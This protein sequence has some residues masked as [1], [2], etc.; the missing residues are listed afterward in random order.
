M[1]ASGQ[2]S[3]PLSLLGNLS[4]PPTT[5][6]NQ[7]S[8]PFSNLGN[9]TA[10]PTAASGQSSDPFGNLGSVTAPGIAGSS[11]SNDPFAYLANISTTPV[12]S[13]P[14]ATTTTNNNALFAVSNPTPLM[15]TE[16]AM[17]TA[18]PTY[19][20]NDLVVPLETITPGK[21]DCCYHF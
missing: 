19:N 2:P 7:S 15:S 1:G 5:T 20:F 10:P 4:A 21:F 8:D 13:V 18:V 11:Q 12:K 9:F 14:A 17:P 16:T 6:F 3:D